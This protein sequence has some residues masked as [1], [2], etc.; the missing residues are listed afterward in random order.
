MVGIDYGENYDPPKP[1]NIDKL[2]LVD[3]SF[4]PIEKMVE[5][6]NHIGREKM[7][8]IDHHKSAIEEAKR[9][10]LDTLPG[11]REIGKAGCELAWEY[12]NPST[13][14]PEAIR[15][16]GRYDVWDLKDGVLPFQYGMRA[17]V[18]DINSPVWTA[19]LANH[20][21]ALAATK[22]ILR[23]GEAIL[24]YVKL[25]NEKYLASCG[26]ESQLEGHTAI[27]LNRL[28]SSQA[29]E[30]SYDPAKHDMMIAFVR[31]NAAWRVSLFSTKETVDCSAI[32]KQYGG[33]GHKGA[34]G[35]ICDTLP[36]KV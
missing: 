27:V 23:E 16:L 15:L 26:F 24:E 31:K 6:S 21:Q 9:V 12:F 20:A 17:K 25:D 11:A 3:F 28:A 2:Y 18:K 10:G 5:L 35:F 22:E 14:M 33:G 1:E 30:G 34:A 8:W 13:E 36:F 32:A 29:F 19:I 7:V 4:Q